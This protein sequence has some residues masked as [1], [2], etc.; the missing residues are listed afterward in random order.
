MGCRVRPFL[1]SFMREH[2]G[3][4]VVL[5]VHWILTSSTPY[6]IRDRDGTTV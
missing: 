2:K 1:A 4:T 5:L 6:D 3:K